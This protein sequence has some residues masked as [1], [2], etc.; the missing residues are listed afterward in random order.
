MGIQASRV[1]DRLRLR[2]VL[3]V[4]MAFVVAMCLTIVAGTSRAD[5]NVIRDWPSMA[6]TYQIE[7]RYHGLDAPLER[8][9]WRLDYE[10]KHDWR[11]INLENT[12]DA[13]AVGDTTSFQG[14]IFSMYTPDTDETIL[15]EHPEAAVAPE[16]WL[17]PWRDLALLDRGYTVEP[18]IK[19]D[20]EVFTKTV[21]V[22]CQ[23]DPT[24]NLTGMIQPEECLTSAVFDRTETITYRTDVTPPVPVEI[25]I[26]TNGILSTHVQV[27]E[28]VLFVDGERVTMIQ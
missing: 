26:E 17:I 23:P 24:G 6:M 19:A 25:V 28:L 22:P 15:A 16:E 14:S 7:G 5:S 4:A 10:D 27:R 11:K 18:S 21:T 1:V 12:V 8:K 20:L 3:F 13:N 9:T 2:A